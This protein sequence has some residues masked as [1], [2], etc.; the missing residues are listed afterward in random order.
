MQ[1]HLQTALWEAEVVVIGVL[2]CERS[3]YIL[4]TNAALTV[5]LLCRSAHHFHDNNQFIL[6]RLDWHHDH[7]T[8][9]IVTKATEHWVV[10]LDPLTAV[11]VVFTCNAWEMSFKLQ[12]AL[13]I[14]SA[15]KV[16]RYTCCYNRWKSDLPC[17]FP[18]MNH[19]EELKTFTVLLFGRCVIRVPYY[20]D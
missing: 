18:S 11:L 16:T 17:T 20:H 12:F 15:L 14:T 4:N 10:Q 19:E 1:F 13:R 5:K 8:S 7:R 3:R 2:L 9:I 6:S